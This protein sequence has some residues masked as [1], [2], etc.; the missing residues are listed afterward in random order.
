MFEISLCRLFISVANARLETN[1]NLA[2]GRYEKQTFFALLEVPEFELPLQRAV[3][4]E[5][6]SN[7]LCRESEVLKCSIHSSAN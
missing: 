2:N 3:H 1:G 6:F 7:F 4:G 5:G